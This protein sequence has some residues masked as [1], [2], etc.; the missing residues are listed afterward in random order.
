MPKEVLGDL[1]PERVVQFIP[2]DPGF[3]IIVDP[4]MAIVFAAAPSFT[5]EG[6]PS[7]QFRLVERRV[8][9]IDRASLA[10][11]GNHVCSPFAALSCH[12]KCEAKCQRCTSGQPKDRA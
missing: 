8:V 7:S 5:P 10:D 9:A 2:D 11:A 3:L 1:S 12:A 4:E 6:C